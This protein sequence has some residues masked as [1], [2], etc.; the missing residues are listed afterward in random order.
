M[1]KMTYMLWLMEQS[2]H[3]PP[4]GLAVC[5][6]ATAGRPGGS[7]E[8]LRGG[9]VVPNLLNCSSTFIQLQRFNVVFSLP[10]VASFVTMFVAS[11]GVL[12]FDSWRMLQQVLT[13]L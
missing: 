7:E 13:H 8:D 12:M 6:P 5:L 11:D 2:R 9:H 1:N 3:L 10:P 4:L